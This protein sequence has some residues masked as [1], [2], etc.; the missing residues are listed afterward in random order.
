MRC[1]VCKDEIDI[2]A[3]YSIVS[4]QGEFR[5]VHRQ[6]K[7]KIIELIRGKQHDLGRYTNNK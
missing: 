3:G 6:C 7:N 1:T 4:H 2:N 5:F